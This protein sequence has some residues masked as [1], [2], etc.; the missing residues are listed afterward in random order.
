MIA[1][2]GE[3]V[4]STQGVREACASAGTQVA[5]FCSLALKTPWPHWVLYL[6]HRLSQQT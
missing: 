3:V 4:S 2:P 5:I 1:P 6:A